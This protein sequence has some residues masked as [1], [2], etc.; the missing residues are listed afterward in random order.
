MANESLTTHAVG[1]SDGDC[2]T[3]NIQTVVGYPQAIAT[4]QDLNREGFVELPKT[5]IFDL[6]PGALE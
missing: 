5:D 2:S 1:V 3:V 6:Y 4:V